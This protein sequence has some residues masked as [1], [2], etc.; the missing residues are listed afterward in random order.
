MAST[1]QV[2]NIERRGTPTSGNWVQGTLQLALF[3]SVS[4]SCERVGVTESGARLSY[5]HAGG[6]PASL[7]RTVGD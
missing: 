6:V 2:T 4:D 7:E 1:G 3:V 5:V